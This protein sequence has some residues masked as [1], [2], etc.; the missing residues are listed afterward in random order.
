MRDSSPN[1]ILL[2]VPPDSTK[3]SRTPLYIAIFAV[4]ILGAVLYYS[5]NVAHVNEKE[6]E[7]TQTHIA[8]TEE[9]LWLVEGSGLSL[10]ADKE[11]TG[12][13]VGAPPAPEPKSAP[14]PIIVVRDNKPPRN[15]EAE[16]IRRKRAQSFLA[17]L[18]SPLLSKKVNDTRTLPVNTVTNVGERHTRDRQTD[19][20]S[21]VSSYRSNDGN[22][23]DP[24]AEQD[25][26]AFFARTQTSDKEWILNNTRTAGQPLELKTGT[27]VPSVMV[28]GVNSDLPGMLIAQVSQNVFDTATGQ[29]LLVPQGSK[30]FGVYDSRVVYGQSRVLVAWN[31]IIYPDGSALTLPSMPG[32][33]MVGNAGF[34]DQVDNHYF[35]IFGSAV[36]MSLIVG[37]TAYAVDSAGDID[38]DETSL[39]SQMTSA[40]AQQLGQTTTQVLQKN[41]T[42]KPTLEI[43]PGYQFNIVLT[44]D[45]VFDSAYTAWRK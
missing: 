1:G 30:L 44:K 9:P 32:V 33:D 38:E 14:E 24:R 2:S 23:Y 35:R 7:A 13:V 22:A 21:L 8:E 43:R 45:V 4:F 5:I 12:G 40:L 37:G 31:R 41:L 11:Q 3:M 39:Q 16:Q 28:T 36:L 10:H 6:E 27:V 34:E 26:E 15:E 19:N 29:N 18:E 20:A 25:K 42:I 17:A